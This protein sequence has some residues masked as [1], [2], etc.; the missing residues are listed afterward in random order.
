MS[1]A[2]L[3]FPCLAFGH[4]GLVAGQ[5]R[6]LPTETPRFFYKGSLISDTT[7]PGEQK[8]DNAQ[9]SNA[10][11]WQV[12]RDRFIWIYVITTFQGADSVRAIAYQLRQG[13]PD[14]KLVREAVLS[15]AVEKWDAFQNGEFF[16]KQQGHGKVFGVPK[17][18]IDAQGKLLPSNNVFCGLWYQ[19]PRPIDRTTGRLLLMKDANAI[20]AQAQHERHTRL[21]SVQFRLNDREDDIEFLTPLTVLSQKGYE[22]GNVFCSLGQEVTGVN[23]WYTPLQPYNA[24]CTQWVDIRHFYPRGIAPVLME[25]NGQTGRYEWIKT[26]SLSTLAKGAM[27]EGFI[28]RLGEEWIIGARAF[29]QGAGTETI[30]YKT[31]DLFG[32]LGPPFLTPSPGAPHANRSAY[33]CGD[34][35]LRIFGGNLATSPFN[36]SRNPQYCWDVDP[37]T[38]ELSNGKTVL[39]TDDIGMTASNSVKFRTFLSPVFQNK[40]IVTITVSK[41]IVGRPSEEELEKY[42]VHYWYVT[43][44]KEIKDPWQFA[45]R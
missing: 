29:K 44:D 45:A 40:Q 39:S 14:G 5:T 20:N 37:N 41:E 16:F 8:K 2:R 7:I 22:T 17:G 9:P 32:G 30:W 24:N 27:I 19:V 36:W 12:S 13:T 15:P 4:L 35:V 6:A 1:I 43:Y 28:N 38:F 25:F 11:C 33:V 42:G 3:V 26:G 31:R 21:G 18:A 23:H 10:V 34:G